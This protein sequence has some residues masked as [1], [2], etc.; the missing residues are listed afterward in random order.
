MIFAGGI[1]LRRGGTIIGPIGVRAG[2]EIKTK[3]SPLCSR[4]EHRS[5]ID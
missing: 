3:W 2:M 4:T 1:P 5:P